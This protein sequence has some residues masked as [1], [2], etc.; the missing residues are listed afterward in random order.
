M[1][2]IR[3][4]SFR[5]LLRIFNTNVDGS[6]LAPFAM[7]KIK[8]VGRRFAIIAMKKANVPVTKRAG[9][10]TAEEEERL[11]DVIRNPLKYKIPVWMLNKQKCVRTGNTTQVLANEIA[12]N[13]REDLERLRRARCNRGIRH[14]LGIKVRG[15]CTKSTG[16]GGGVLGVARKK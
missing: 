6:I 14:A 4:E 2:L 10:L 3:P 13:L 1:S 8:G 11:V 15:Q 12:T 16:R 7:T 9:E 5:D